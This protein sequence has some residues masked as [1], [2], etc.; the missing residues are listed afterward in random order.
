[1]GVQI[2]RRRLEA[3][4]ALDVNGTDTTHKLSVLL[5]LIYGRQFNYED[6]YTEGITQIHPFD[7]EFAR[8][9]GYRIKLLAIFKEEQGQIEAR[10]HPT[11][12]PGD[13]LLSHVKGIYNAIFIKGDAVGSTMF[14]GQGAGMMPTGSAVV[15]D[16]IDISQ[17]IL[18]GAKGRNIPFL[19]KSDSNIK[20]KQKNM[21]RS[22]YYLRFSALDR[23]GV[24]SQISGILGKYSI[25]ISS[26]IQRG[27][28]IDGA[29]P[30]FTLIHESIEE[31]VDKALTEIDAL[32][33]TLGKTM[34][35]RIEDQ[36][37]RLI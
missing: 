25:S 33:V 13:S 12:I 35:I 34:V 3:D 5:S 28:Q 4:P 17:N 1:M 31:H 26:V 21:L 2:V 24:L 20:L 15:S 16:I 10:V 19:A 18:N 8:E 22:K 6:I 37:D 29:V 9:L 32:P 11:L 30:I 36:F 23:P 7:I 27:R 14:Y